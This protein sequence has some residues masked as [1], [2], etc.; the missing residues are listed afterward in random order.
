[1]EAL[2]LEEKLLMVNERKVR[3]D[4]E[5]VGRAIMDLSK[6]AMA[7]DE[8]IRKQRVCQ[9]CFILLWCFAPKMANLQLEL[10]SQRDQLLAQ[11][12]HL[13]GDMRSIRIEIRYMDVD[14]M[15]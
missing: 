2:L 15:P 10:E 1:M 3:E 6:Q 9:A 13:K 5:S 8:D 7:S 12:K 14:I 11:Q 4:L